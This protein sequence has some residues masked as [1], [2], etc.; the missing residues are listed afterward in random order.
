MKKLSNTFRK[1]L[2][3]KSKNSTS[4]FSSA[5]LLN[6]KAGDYILYKP[7]ISSYSVVGGDNGTGVGDLKTL[8]LKRLP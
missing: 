5:K 7:E 8:P 2:S 6:M 4:T 1:A 3:S